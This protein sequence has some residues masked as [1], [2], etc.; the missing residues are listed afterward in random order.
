MSQ[1]LAEVFAD[2]NRVPQGVQPNSE[3]GQ[4]SKQHVPPEPVLIDCS[5]HITTTGFCFNTWFEYEYLHLHLEILPQGLRH[6]DT[7]IS[8]HMHDHER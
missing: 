8:Y 2:F 3:G 7:G 4:I 1:C 6:S 5:S